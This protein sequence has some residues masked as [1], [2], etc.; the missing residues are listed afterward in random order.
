MIRGTPLLGTVFERLRTKPG[1]QLRRPPGHFYSPIPSLDEVRANEERLF[2]VPPRSIAGINLNEEKQLELFEDFKEFYAQLPF[3]TS[4]SEGLRYYYEN[5]YFL[6][7]DAIFLFCMLRKMKPKRIIEVGSGFSSCVTLDTNELF[8]DDSI[9][10]TFIE[11]FPKRLLSLIK[12]DDQNR[13]RLIEKKL[14]DVPLELFE[15]LSCG[16]FLFIDSTHVSKIGSDV[17]FIFFDIL[18][19]LRS[20]V[21]I[22]FHDIFYP[23][24]YP[25][26]WVYEGEVWNEAYLL[27]AFLQYNEDFEIVFYNTFLAHFHEKLIEREMPLCTRNTGGSLWIRKK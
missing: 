14:Q 24:E 23:F 17:N 22:H 5:D 13:I 2:G 19:A 8:F 27:R 7:A 16:D 10:T 4:E 25:K 11:P 26:V 1:P 3:S 9:E 21:F 15:S 18:P 12:E 20:G 6:Y